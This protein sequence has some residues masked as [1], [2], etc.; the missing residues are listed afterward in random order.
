VKRID[1]LW[2]RTRTV[3]CPDGTH[4]EVYKNIDNIFPIY[5]KEFKAS[6]SATIKAANDIGGEAAAQYE[7]R[8][9]E[10]LFRIDDYNKS[11]QNQLRSAY[12]IYEANPCEELPYLKR[13]IEEINARE[14]AL[15]R[16][17]A[18]V[19][20]VVSIAQACGAGKVEVDV[21]AIQIGENLS[22]AIDLLGDPP[23]AAVLIENMAD[24]PTAAQEWRNGGAR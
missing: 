5:L 22:K 2:N 9:A 15:R 7:D 10:L 17:D 12:V 3:T 8:I 13:T 16:A 11:S 4:R 21:A 24:A 23:L 6:S 20:H 19:K 14:H 18:A 1:W